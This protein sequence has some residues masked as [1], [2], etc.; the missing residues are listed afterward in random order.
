MDREFSLQELIGL[1]CRT[2]ADPVL[3]A[4]LGIDE[5]RLKR[6]RQEA[7]RDTS[8]NTSHKRFGIATAFG[9]SKMSPSIRCPP[10]IKHEVRLDTIFLYRQGKDRFRQY[11]DSLPFDIQFGMSLSI[12][13][14]RLGQPLDERG[15]E[16]S[17]YLGIL[18]KRLKYDTGDCF[19]WFEF[20]SEEKVEMVVLVGYCY[21]SG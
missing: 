16:V 2:G 18:P 6:L 9:T 4:A 20:D 5:A 3:Q 15:G 8:A 14:E 10:G 12:L 17:P 1:L 7:A 13:K 11:A 19:V 21:R